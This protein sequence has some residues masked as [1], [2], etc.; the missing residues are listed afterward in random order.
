MYH[1]DISLKKEKSFGLGN[2]TMIRL[3]GF[4][5]RR[6]SPRIS[7]LGSA[8]W[9]F[10]FANSTSRAESLAGRR[11]RIHRQDSIFEFPFA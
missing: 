3:R 4:L 7:T 8:G 11:G 1:G 5:L 10:H 2:A 9:F 6:N